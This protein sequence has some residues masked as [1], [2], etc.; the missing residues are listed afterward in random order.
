[1][2]LLS[3]LVI[4]SEL[5]SCAHIT[6]LLSLLR[7]AR[8]VTAGAGAAGAEGEASSLLT[9]STLTEEGVM[10][11]K[12][13]ACDRLLSFRVELKVA[14][15]RIADVL[16]RM[17]VAQPK[18]RCAGGCR[19]KGGRGHSCCSRIMAA[20]GYCW[21]RLVGGRAVA[22]GGSCCGARLG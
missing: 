19:R 22:H 14:G 2:C 9:M 7:T 3:A 11:V 18:H 13:T 5:S 4:A 15:K 6:K 10:A 1:M 12:Q 8:R 17:H 21:C 20:A 16:N